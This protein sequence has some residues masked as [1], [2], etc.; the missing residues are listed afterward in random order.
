MDDVMQGSCA[1]EFAAVGLAFA[2][3]FRSRGEVGAAVSVR[4]DGELVVDL[5][6]GY[7]DEAKS[8]PW[9]ADTLVCMMSVGKGMA[10]LCVL[11]LV[12]RGKIAL[13]RPVAFYWPEFAQAGKGDVT[14]RHVLSSTSGVLFADTAPPLSVMDWTAMTTAIAAQPAEW[15]PGARGA[16]QSMT[17]GFM[18]GELVRRVDGRTLKQYFAE[19]VTGPLNVEYTWGLDDDEI[20]RTADIIGNAAHD[21]VKA[22]ADRT[23]N[24]GRAWH[25]RPVGPQFYNTDMFRQGVLPSSNGHGTAHGVAAIYA[26]MLRDDEL[27][28]AHTRELMRTL[29]WHETCGM[30]G[31]PYRY[32]HGFFLNTEGLVP[33]GTNPKAFG[34]PGAGG[35]LGFADPEARI[36]FAYAPNAMCAGAGSGER[37]HAL[38]AALYSLI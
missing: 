15:S 35:A 4:V 29:A 18:L 24:L 37:C 3:N 21:T 12:E 26:A 16:Y 30:T 7:A 2:E 27:I 6:G 5:W 25:M 19:E 9:A 36:A 10:A 20:A 33:M 31:R 14:V 1:P 11:Q 23:T 34:H 13:D 28:S 38:V 22:F 32:G 17:M 8:R